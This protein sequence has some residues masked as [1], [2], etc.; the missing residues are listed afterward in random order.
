MSPI[1]ISLHDT[2]TA[3][4]DEQV[5]QQ[6][7]GTS[8][9]NVRDLIRKDHDRLQLRNSLLKGAGS[10]SA[11]PSDK[12]YFKSL[13]DR[14][15]SGP[16]PAGSPKPYSRVRGTTGMLMPPSSAIWSGM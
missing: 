1:N 6:G 2:V 8:S 5:I 15:R 3:L 16:K 13:R 10:K 4:V 9:E 14:I 7:D 11:V 12:A